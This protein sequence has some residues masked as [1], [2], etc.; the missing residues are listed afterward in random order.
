MKQLLIEVDDVVAAKLEQVAPGRTRR[1]SEF[2]RNAIRR[3]LWELEEAAT[4]EAYRR[5]PDS[6]K[7]AYLAPPVWEARPRRKRS[8][9]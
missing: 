7:D 1:R 3:A 5:H 9:R 4:A 8:R 2:V 6:T